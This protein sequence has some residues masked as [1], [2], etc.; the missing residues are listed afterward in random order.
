MVL[1]TSPLATAYPSEIPSDG[2]HAAFWMVYTIS[3]VAVLIGIIMKVQ[4]GWS[5]AI[6]K[7]V[8]MAAIL[9]GIVPLAWHLH[10][11]R[12]DYVP[13]DQDGTRASPPIW[14]AIA[15]PALPVLCGCCLLL[16]KRRRQPKHL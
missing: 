7:K 3:A 8:A 9:T 1:P 16:L 12:I 10:L 13:Y 4:Q 15:I 11:Y 14:R 5:P 6:E 2:L